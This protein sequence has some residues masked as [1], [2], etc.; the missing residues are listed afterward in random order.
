M[1]PGASRASEGAGDGLARRVAAFIESERLLSGDGPLLVAV[2]G[3]VDSTVLLHL[4]RYP[5]ARL[6]TVVAATF[7]HRMRPGSTADAAWVRGLCRAWDVPLEEGRAE[8][9]PGSEAE[10]RRL[11]YAFLDRTAEAI[12]ARVVLTGHHADDQVET[13]LFRLLRGAGTRGIAGIPMRR[14][15]VVRPL[16]PVRRRELERYAVRHGVAWRL[17]PTNR[18]PRYARNL[19]R[20]VMLPRIE[21]AAPGFGD[22]LLEL[23]A[24]ARD[25]E[26]AWSGVE[27]A[28]LGDVIERRSER[29]VDVARTRLLAYDSEV[30][31]RVLRRLLRRFGSSPGR[32]GTRAALEFISS[33][34]SGTRVQVA[35]GVCIARDFDRIRIGYPDPAETPEQVVEIPSPGRGRGTLRLGGTAWTVRWRL[36]DREA[37]RGMA[38]AVDALRFPLTV[39]GWRPGDRIRLGGGTRKLKK[40]F[41]ERRIPVRRR[42]RIPV[43]VDAGGA[44]LWVVGVVRSVAAPAMERGNLEVRV[45]DAQ[46]DG[47]DG[48]CVRAGA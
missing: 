22:T 29:A 25:V 16:L 46:I 17:D 12:G 7:D 45:D 42:G 20:H 40:V 31:A 48:A 5:L 30:V 44:V 33:G 8:R 37:G 21:A 24:A 19:I 23:A 47:H 3:G 32:A 4:L 39:R 26:R 41:G 43:L 15:R 18:D 13:V 14:G 35:G 34:T 28:V 11:R 1:Q 38:F 9:V 10:A 6:G 27:R 36:K 2:S